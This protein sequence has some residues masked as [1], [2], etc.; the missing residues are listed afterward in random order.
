[1]RRTA[2]SGR[3]SFARTRDI[4]SLRSRGVKVSMARVN[5]DPSVSHRPSLEN[6]APQAKNWTRAS[7]AEGAYP[8]LLMYSARASSRLTNLRPGVRQLRSQ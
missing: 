8:K 6:S 1:M 3:V 7:R 4:I 5:R 2:S